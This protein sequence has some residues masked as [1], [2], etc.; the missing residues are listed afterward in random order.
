MLQEKDMK[1]HAGT[2]IVECLSALKVEGGVYI[3]FCE[4]ERKIKPLTDKAGGLRDL[5]SIITNRTC[6]L[7]SRFLAIKSVRL[8][9][10]WSDSPFGYLPYSENVNILAQTGL[11]DSLYSIF[12]NQEEHI[13]LR[14]IVSDLLPVFFHDCD[15]SALSASQVD[16]QIGPLYQVKYQAD[17]SLLFRLG[18]LVK[19]LGSNESAMALDKALTE[20]DGRIQSGMEPEEAY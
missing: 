12:R 9:L 10:E 3:Y 8:F 16:S 5:V 11:L 15:I 2:A 20:C 7:P 13:G 1:R 4:H 18:E 6:S 19:M 14:L 17:I